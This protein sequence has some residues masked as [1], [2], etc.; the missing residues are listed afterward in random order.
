VEIWISTILF[1][2]GVLIIVKAGDVFVTASV[3]IARHVHIPRVVIG[4]TLVSLATTVP[5]MT[6]SA[7][8]SMQGNAGLAV[9]NA[10]GSVICNIGLIVGI[11]CLLH[12]L[13]VRV[14]DFRFPAVFMLGTGLLLTALTVPLQLGHPRGILLV[15]CGIV[16]LTVD[17]VRHRRIARKRGAEV[18]APSEEMW[19]LSCSII[20]F[21]L[22]T[23]AVIVGSRLMSHNGVR[24]ATILGVSPM[25]I[26]LTLVAVGTSLP[27]LVTA[28][29][30]AR[31]GVPELSL[32]NVIGANIMNITLITGV[33]GVIHP[34]TMT[35]NTQL[36]NFP[37][38][39]LMILL[40]LVQGRTGQQL[41]RQE[42]LV[43]L[44]FYVFYVGGLFLL[45]A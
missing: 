8:A 9:G 25:V 40:L 23:G 19:S 28:V 42:G 34:L 14:T 35:R 20:F 27:E 26:G 24:L 32:G 1:V 15:I 39:L 16:Y 43:F 45:Q 31:K 21:V 2:F 4:G 36:Y 44:L 6:V 11:L 17:T 10:V 38:M 12:P 29:T 18:E 3:A 22:A 5:E 33:A 7:I 41:S 37:A 13:P 30:A